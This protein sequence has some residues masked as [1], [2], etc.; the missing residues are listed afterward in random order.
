MMQNRSGSNVVQFARSKGAE[1]PVQGDLF[2]GPPARDLRE[3]KA[4]AT[5]QAIRPTSPPITLQADSQDSPDMWRNEP[6]SAFAIW[7]RSQLVNKRQIAPHSMEQYGTMFGAYVRWLLENQVAMLDATSA[8]VE[9]F[10]SSRQGRPAKDGTTELAAVST[11]RRYMQLIHSVY[12][13]L[14]QLGLRKSNPVDVILGLQSNKNFVKPPPRILDEK[15]VA[16]YEA[17]CLESDVST[18]HRLRDRAMRLLFLGSGI[19]VAEMQRL[20]PRSVRFEPDGS[21]AL[22]IVAH[23]FTDAHVAPVAQFASPALLEW[24]QALQANWPGIEPLFPARK[25]GFSTDYPDGTPI[26]ATECFLVIQEALRGAGYTD[27]NQGPQTL[28]NTFIARQIRAGISRERIRT[29][30]GLATDDTIDR[31]HKLVP[32]REGDPAPV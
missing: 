18:W 32:L 30:C 24:M 7:K 13:H 16:A 4:V 23:G 9:R 2:G 22:E 12:E 10:L 29:W 25:F 26:P 19:T 6:D 31:I 5:V 14:R 3:R 1:A 27:S 11:R 20:T 17:Y 28:R 8:D 21:L 15:V